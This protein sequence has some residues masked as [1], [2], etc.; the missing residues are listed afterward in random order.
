[1]LAIQDQNWSSTGTELVGTKWSCVKDNHT[2]LI[3]EV[4]TDDDGLHDKD[5]RYTWYNTDSASNGGAVGY[6]NDDGNICN[7][8]KNS[9]SATYCNTQ[10]FVARVNKTK[11]CG[12]SDWRMPTRQELFSITHFGRINPSIDSK[13][14]PNTPSKNF[15]SSSPDANNSDGAWIVRFNGGHDGYGGRSSHNHV[16]L[17]RASQ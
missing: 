14:F 2:G 9:D 13:Y 12:A 5:D 6:A 3:W 8:Y 1:V 10:A 17:V 4:K 7:G 11:L 16:R 15:W